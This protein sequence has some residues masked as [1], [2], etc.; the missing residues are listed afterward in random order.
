MNKKGFNKTAQFENPKESEGYKKLIIDLEKKIES[1][2]L[3]SDEL[4][5]FPITERIR[6]SKNT[7][8][9][10]LK[11]QIEAK[12]TQKKVERLENLKPAI[13][14]KFHG[15]PNLP[16]TP[17]KIRRQRELEQMSRLS[18][19]L[20]E[21]V[22]IKKQNALAYKSLELEK[23]KESNHLD[24]KK[25]MD[26]KEMKLMKKY[27]E[28]QVLVNAWSQ[29]QKAKELQDILE[30]SQRKG[31]KPRSF[32]ESSE[33]EQKYKSKAEDEALQ[34]NLEYELPAESEKTAYK[35]ASVGPKKYENKHLTK[36]KAQ[37][38]KEYLDNKAKDTYQYKIKQLIND[39]KKQREKE[40]KNYKKSY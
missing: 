10:E 35:N 18:Q 12:N 36:E 16:Q 13:S 20:S 31:V 9:E 6:G 19:G 21:Q 39:A 1:R 5:T 8:A 15:Y 4:Y 25:L 27:S 29:A 40:R 2:A 7:Y 32:F 34:T 23:D 24:V 38:L 26:D 37:K 22:L 14:E 17:P 28:K 33:D 3:S 30:N 11:R